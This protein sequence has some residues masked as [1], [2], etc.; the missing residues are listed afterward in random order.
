MIDWFDCIAFVRNSKIETWMGISFF[1][2]KQNA[3]LEAR[4]C[5][6]AC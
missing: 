1:P 3:C 5:K 4:Q 6:S 2:D